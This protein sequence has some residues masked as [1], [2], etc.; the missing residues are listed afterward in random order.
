MLALAFI[1]ILQR[2]AHANAEPGAVTP[3]AAMMAGDREN[4]CAELRVGRG[5]AA[6]VRQTAGALPLRQ[7]QLHPVRSASDNAPKPK[8]LRPTRT[9]AGGRGAA[10]LA[11][12]A[13]KA[14]PRSPS[15][16]AR[17][18]SAQAARARE[19]RST[20]ASD[21]DGCGNGNGIRAY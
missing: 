21:L 4:R 9:R 7:K 20:H 17:C 14:R 12:R 15:N 19:H 1:C 10:E 2:L 16:C 6:S 11:W 18:R 5:A 13:Q 8:K 3:A